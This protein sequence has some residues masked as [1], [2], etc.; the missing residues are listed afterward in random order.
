MIKDKGRAAYVIEMHTGANPAEAKA[1]A[2]E[3]IGEYV[4]IEVGD[5]VGGPL[6]AVVM[7]VQ[8]VNGGSRPSGSLV[9]VLAYSDHKREYW[10]W[11]ADARGSL[12]NGVYSHVFEKALATFSTRQTDHLYRHFNR[13]APALTFA[14]VPDR[15]R[16][17][18]GAKDGH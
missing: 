14:H 13:M 2:E 12:E 7:A 18:D 6:G 8:Y 15:D 9:T 1:A 11:T 3:I 16:L 17:T 10:V 5:T 4:P